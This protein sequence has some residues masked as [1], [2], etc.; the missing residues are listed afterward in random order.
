[1]K[2]MPQDVFDTAVLVLLRELTSHGQEALITTHRSIVQNYQSA[3]GEDLDFPK[4]LIQAVGS[5]NRHFSPNR[6]QRFDEI[7]ERTIALRMELDE[8]M[9]RKSSVKKIFGGSVFKPGHPAPQIRASEAE[10]HAK[11]LIK[12]IKELP[13][14]HD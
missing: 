13:P 10:A 6:P 9:A 2:F 4:Q 14:F 12:F 3:Y 7:L 1:M 8:N 11:Y 5:L